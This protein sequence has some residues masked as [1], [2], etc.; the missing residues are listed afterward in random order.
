MKNPTKT[1]AK[2]GQ[3]PDGACMACAGGWKC[4]YHIQE[5]AIAD[6]KRSELLRSV[7]AGIAQTRIYRVC[8]RFELE[9]DE[10]ATRE[11]KAA[12]CRDIVTKDKI[13]TSR[14]HGDIPEGEDAGSYYSRGICVCGR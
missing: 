12:V 1:L 5:D 10:M 3:Y 14:R 6:R 11:E 8:A 4:A 7:A 2:P 13:R 9:S